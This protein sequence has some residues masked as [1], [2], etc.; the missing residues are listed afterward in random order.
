MNS[1]PF[2][3]AYPMARRIAHA[4]A[5]A[6]ASIGQIGCEEVEDVE[7]D[8]VLAFFRR[9]SQY[10][11]TRSSMQTF[12]ALVMESKLI[13]ILRARGAA[14]QRIQQFCVPLPE[15]DSFDPDNEPQ[16][17]AC[18]PCPAGRWDFRI[19]LK[20][21]LSRLPEPI[22]ETAALVDQVSPR[23][24]AQRLGCSRTTFYQRLSELRSACARAGIS[25]GY[26]AKA[27]GAG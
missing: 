13:S 5:L 11:E 26:L 12:A 18:V 1:T 19:D 10:D 6:A 8:L 4:K 20:R 15:E 22:A 23:E 7:S 27:G 2:E 21:V 17:V 24:A 16:S 9:F 3:A 25:V 14:S